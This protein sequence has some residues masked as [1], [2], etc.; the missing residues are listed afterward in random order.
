M[1]EQTKTDEETNGLTNE[2]TNEQR[3]LHKTQS[4]KQYRGKK[5]QTANKEIQNKQCLQV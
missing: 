1:T 5:H 3:T 2:Q 4:I